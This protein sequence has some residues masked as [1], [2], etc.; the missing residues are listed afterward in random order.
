[1]GNCPSLL[2]ALRIWDLE[3]SNVQEVA[4]LR[5]RGDDEVR[6]DQRYQGEIRDSDRIS[7]K[8]LTV[9]ARSKRGRQQ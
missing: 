1:M 3:A 2:A 4:D 5:D 8:R 7:R 9:E 6:V